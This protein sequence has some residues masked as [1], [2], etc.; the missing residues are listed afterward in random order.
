[1]EDIVEVCQ[2]VYRQ[3]LAQTDVIDFDDMILFPLI[4]NLRVKFGKDVIF[5]DEAQDLSRAR[6]ALARKFLKPSGRLVIV[7]DDRQAIYGFSGAD[8]AALDNLVQSMNATVLP[9]SI[10]WRCPKAVVSL[11]QTIVPDIEAAPTAPE[12]VVST[13]HLQDEAAWASLA[14]EFTPKTPSCAG[15]RR[16]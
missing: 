9:L 12:G 6:Q 3:S 2:Q 13:V 1:M 8:A 16:R 14:S 4:K 5:L 7:G 11:A 15:I 10:T